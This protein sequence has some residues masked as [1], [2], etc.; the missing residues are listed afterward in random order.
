V[1]EGR[2][3]DDEIAA[4]SRSNREILEVHPPAGV[5][6]EV[7][8]RAIAE[9]RKRA[10]P[11]R[12]LVFGGALVVAGALALVL[13]PRPKPEPHAP[14]PFLTLE[15]TG[16]KGDKLPPRTRLYVYRHDAAGNQLLHEGAGAARGDL[17]QL[18]YVT[19]DHA[20]GVLLSIDGSG[21]VTQHW[22]EPG[23]RSA[24]ELHAGNEVQVPSSY[25]L[26]DAPGFE[27]FF[28]VAA[29]E[30]F[31]LGP[32]LKAART[33]GSQPGTARRAALPLPPAFA[34]VSVA[35]D[36]SQTRRSPSK[37]TP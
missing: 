6:T 21:K 17:L 16:I 30:S 2:S 4:L 28:L 26:D 37:E 35:L 27:R 20:F 5:A 1:A 9:A 23:A 14:V 13:L 34:Q 19:I 12:T 33:L 25:E 10:R 15:E 11:R 29:G 32:I 18:T 22:P 36:K 31:E 24:P 8:R 3:P 7:R